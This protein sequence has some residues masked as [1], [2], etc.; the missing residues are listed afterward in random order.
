M[1]R[2]E[3]HQGSLELGGKAPAI[4]MGDA[5]LDLAV[6][7]IRASRIINTARCATAPNGCMFT[8]L[9]PRSSSRR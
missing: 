8:S 7:A 2:G 3:R 4:V 6:R 5:D 1:L 9:W